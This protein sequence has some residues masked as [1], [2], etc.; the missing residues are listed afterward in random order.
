MAITING[1]SN[2]ITG[3]AVGGLPDGVVDTDMLA[4]NAVTAAKA[5]GS[6]K[7]I[8]ELDQWCLTSDNSSNGDITSNLSRNSFS[9]SAC[10]LGTGMSQSSGVFSFPSTG[11]YLVIC[12]ANLVLS[13]SDNVYIQTQV[14]LNNGT[15]FTAVTIAG[16]GN[17]GSGDRE[18]Q[19]TSFYFL[20]VTDIS[21]VKV[22]FT[23]ISI[24]G[25][26]FVKGDSS[27]LGTSFTFIR[28]GDT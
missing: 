25:N 5:T 17:N 3:L 28:I 27:Q 26:S 22:K 18:G 24:S 11:K 21:Q 15:S 1:S 8:T 4:A 23:I 20:D 10:P 12:E 14:T 13:D 2:T 7:G 16:D 6:A 9:G 19:G